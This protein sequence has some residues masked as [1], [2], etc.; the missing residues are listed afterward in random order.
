MATEHCVRSRLGPPAWPSEG[1]L[2][3]ALVWDM[4]GPL[5]YRGYFDEHSIQFGRATDAD[6]QAVLHLYD[7]DHIVIGHTLVDDVGWLDADKKII[8]IDI[9]WTER[10]EAEGLLVEN[11]ELRRWLVDGEK[12][13]LSHLRGN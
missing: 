3:T 12:R 13:E 6:V 5:W 10:E 8:A 11:G 1:D 7:V 4:Q 9:H 2:A